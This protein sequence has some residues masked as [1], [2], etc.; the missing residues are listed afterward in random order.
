MTAFREVAPAVRAAGESYATLDDIARSDDRVGIDVHVPWW[1]T[2]D[3][4][5]ALLRIRALSVEDEAA[6]ERAGRLAAARYRKEYPF[7]DQPP[8]SDWKAEYEEV[9]IRGV[10]IPAMDRAAARS[11]MT[12]NARAI[13]DL[14]RFIRILN[15]LS[16][17]SIDALVTSQSGA[18]TA[19]DASSPGSKSGLDDAPSADATL[20]A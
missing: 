4:K 18:A 19:P 2:L 9:L 10:V 12:K 14:V 13:D 5:P 16:Q 17:E 7:D 6:I 15:S 3:G 1:H 8:A 11:L 20:G